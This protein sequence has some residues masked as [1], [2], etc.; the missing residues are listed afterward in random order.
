[1]DHVSFVLA[2]EKKNMKNTAIYLFLVQI[3]FSASH[4]T[5]KQ[6][7][8]NGCTLKHLEQLNVQCI[9]CKLLSVKKNKKAVKNQP[10][11]NQTQTSV[12]D[13]CTQ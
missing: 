11:E 13:P 2:F 8:M 4:Y 7:N 12:S 10:K 9:G 1:M 3:F 5:G 6:C